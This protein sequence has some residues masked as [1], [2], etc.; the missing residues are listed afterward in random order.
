[1]VRSSRVVVVVVDFI[2]DICRPEDDQSPQMAQD[3]RILPTILI[4]TMPPLLITDL[5][6]MFEQMQDQMAAPKK[7]EKLLG[8]ICSEKLSAKELSEK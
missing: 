3:Q 1:L 8:S 5:H 6:P 2:R 4:T 7:N